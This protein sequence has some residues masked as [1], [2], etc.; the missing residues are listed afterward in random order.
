LIG[1][2]TQAVP[3]HIDDERKRAAY[4]FLMWI[5]DAEVQRRYAEAGGIV[6]NQQVYDSDLTQQYDFRGG[7]FGALNRILE[8]VGLGTQNWLASY[9]LALPALMLVD[10]WHWTPIV[11]IVVFAAFHGVDRSL[12]EA[13]RV[14]GA[15]ELRLV[16]HTS[17]AM[18]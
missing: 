5:T 2:W 17:E 9:P 3:V 10:V 8:A 14:D 13:A 7:E 1:A 6:T 16:W 12:F 4:D 18:T 15:S 11:F